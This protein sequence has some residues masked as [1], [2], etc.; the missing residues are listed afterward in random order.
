MSVSARVT[1][2]VHRQVVE[3]LLEHSLNEGKI[4]PDTYGA[5]IDVL[6]IMNP[7][8]PVQLEIRANF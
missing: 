5:L 2:M 8:E 3:N 7:D 1:Q 4:S 6:S